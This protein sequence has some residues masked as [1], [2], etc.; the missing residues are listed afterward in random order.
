MNHI[1]KIAVGSTLCLAL[2]ACS[3]TTVMNKMGLGKNPPDETQIVTNN[4]LALPPDL[5]LRPPAPGTASEQQVQQATAGTAVSSAPPDAFTAPAETNTAAVEPAQVAAV[6]ANPYDTGEKQL[7]TDAGTT[8]SITGTEASPSVQGTQKRDLSG[9]AAREDA[10][11]RFGISKTRP[12]GKPKTQPE[13]DREL[14]EAVR[15]EKRRQ[16]P[17]YGTVFNIGELFKRN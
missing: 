11:K 3:E 5:Q 14:L 1:A 16:N 2:L 17:S 6:D 12:D 9:N 15:A 10:Y 4:Q 13:L 8:A 7:A